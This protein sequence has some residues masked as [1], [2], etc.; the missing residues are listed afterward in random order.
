V[1]LLLRSFKEP[2]DISCRL[3][4]SLLVFYE[5]NADEPVAVLSETDARRY[6]NVGAFQ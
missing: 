2:A 5:T 4:Q 3:A 1:Q 6:R